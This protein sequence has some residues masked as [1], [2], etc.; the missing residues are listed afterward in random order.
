M[1]EIRKQIKDVGIGE[2][3]T[4]DASECDP[5]YIMLWP[6]TVSIKVYPDKIE[7]RK[8]NAACVRQGVGLEYFDRDIWVDV[9][10]DAH[11]VCDK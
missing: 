10:P 11:M 4:Q 1:I 8:Y 3:F 5:W 7:E 2:V 9:L 6:I